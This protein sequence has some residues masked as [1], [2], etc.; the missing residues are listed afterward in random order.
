MD[1]P[2]CEHH[3]FDDSFNTCI[4]DCILKK[5]NISEYDV[6]EFI[7]I[8]VWNTAC[9]RQCSYFGKLPVIKSILN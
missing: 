4:V 8:T 5:S 2:V 7:V 1:F 3:L 9:S 6:L